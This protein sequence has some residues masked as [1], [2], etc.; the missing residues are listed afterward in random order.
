MGNK[1]PKYRKNNVKR[2]HHLLPGISSMLEEIADHP[3]VKSIIPGRINSAIRGSTVQLRLKYKT[4]TGLKLLA[5]SNGGVQ[6]IFIVSNSPES[7]Y[8]TLKQYE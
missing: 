3:A 8:E 4:R 7:L 1:K 6:E 2:E 5:K